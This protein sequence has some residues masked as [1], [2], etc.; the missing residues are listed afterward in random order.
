MLAAVLL[1]IN[2]SHESLWNFLARK[3]LIMLLYIGWILL[4]WT[5]KLWL[6]WCLWFY[7]NMQKV[8]GNLHLTILWYSFENFNERYLHSF[9]F[10]STNYF[11]NKLLFLLLK[12]ILFLEY[13]RFYF[14]I[15]WL[16]N[17][18]KLLKGMQIETLNKILTIYFLYFNNLQMF[19]L[20]FW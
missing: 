6:I 18:S 7:I 19:Q 15:N 10:L 17:E 13:Y 16:I 3:N 11:Y 8:F 12:F 14:Y 2:N 9:F 4:F 20:K 5:S 1:F